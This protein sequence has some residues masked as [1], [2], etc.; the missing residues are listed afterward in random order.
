MR[1]KDFNGEALNNY[2]FLVAGAFAEISSVSF[3]EKEVISCSGKFL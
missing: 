2:C 3:Q 1:G